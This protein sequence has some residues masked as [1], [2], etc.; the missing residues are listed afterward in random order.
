MRE[1]P[2]EILEGFYPT[3]KGAFT[4]RVEEFKS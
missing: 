1:K 4:R 3:T 2:K